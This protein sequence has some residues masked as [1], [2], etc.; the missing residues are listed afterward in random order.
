MA[1]AKTS[2]DTLPGT[3]FTPRQ[4][5]VLKWAV[6]IMG[7]MLVGG[8]ALVISAIVYQASNLGESTP[9]PAA[10]SSSTAVRALVVPSGMSV[11]RMAMGDNRLAVY[12]EGPAASEIRII[13]LG[14]GTL[15]HR[16]PV[17]NE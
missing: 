17:T 16:I 6:I 11:S 9:A 1:E 8:F 15:M 5:R 4:V 2:S 10:T 12:L 14:S 3:V 13:D 7:I